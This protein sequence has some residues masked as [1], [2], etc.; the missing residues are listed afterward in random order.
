MRLT[1][2]GIDEYTLAAYLAGRLAPSRRREVAD[3][4][5]RNEDARDVLYAASQLLETEGDGQ[6]T[7]PPTLTAVSLP[8]KRKPLLTGSRK[9]SVLLWT[10][11]GLVCL[12]AFVTTILVAFRVGVDAGAANLAGPRTDPS[13][14]VTVTGGFEGLS[15]QAAADAEAYQ[16]VVWDDAQDAVVGQVESEVAFV[17][18]E[19]LQGFLG[20]NPR[21]VWI[22]AYDDSGRLLQRTRT[23]T[24]QR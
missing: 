16:V 24:L 20:E 8:P 1:S 6:D 14:L 3:F 18:Y 9:L 4:L 12:T 7:R 11:V 23:V 17:S 10:T 2:R 22:D 5:A 21:R 19:S 15:W 13:S